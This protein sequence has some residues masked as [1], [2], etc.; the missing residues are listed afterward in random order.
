MFQ[1]AICDDQKQ[2]LDMLRNGVGQWLEENVGIN[3]SVSV[4]HY[5][6]ELRDYL[7]RKE[8]TFDLFLLD[9]IM[10]EMDGIEL[11]RAIRKID[12]EVPIIYVTIT[13]EYA[14]EAY[15]IHAIRYL[16]KPYNLK[17]LYS[18]LDFSY[19]LFRMKPKH[20]MLIQGKESV[21]SV[22]IEEIMYIENDLRKMTYTMS[23]GYTIVSVRRSGSFEE[24][25]GPIVSNKNFMQPH[26]SF[27]VN[28]RY[29]RALQSKSI[30]MD[31]GRV[32]PIA[33]NRLADIRAKYIY[34]VSEERE[35][36][37]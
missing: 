17:E 8:K 36:L 2:E 33:R 10:S 5:P 12:A 7:T 15:G 14:L 34:Y 35:K 23:D 29:I 21:T 24:A 4:F 20:T 11:G 22:I 32:I 6:Q 13:P 9:I 25:V 19:A 18:A 27:F 26:K 16:T 3:A 1:I 31:D 37:W 28:I 30:L